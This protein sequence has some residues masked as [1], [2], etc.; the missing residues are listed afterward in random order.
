MAVLA[1]ILALDP[2]VSAFSGKRRP[3]KPND[4]DQRQDYKRD[5]YGDSE[6]P[7]HCRVVCTL[8]APT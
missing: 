4:T 5:T 6:C 7:G 8:H 3:P 1:F 2:G